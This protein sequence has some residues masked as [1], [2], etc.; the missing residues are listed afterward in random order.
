[1]NFVLHPIW[2]KLGGLAWSNPS[3]DD[4]VRIRAA[5][6]RP[7]FDRLLDL[8]M[9]FGVARLRVEWE[10]LNAMPTPEVI[11]ARRAVDRILRH[12]EMGFS[13]ATGVH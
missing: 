7:R 4:S 13:H 1:M 11:R 5:L 6:V 2:K 3:A 12:I 8:A 10:G 9:V